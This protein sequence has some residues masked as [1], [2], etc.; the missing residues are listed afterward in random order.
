MA[1]LHFWRLQQ[2]A[3]ELVDVT[4][5]VNDVQILRATIR[6]TKTV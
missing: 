5:D 6:S 2:I 1:L 4:S 3:L